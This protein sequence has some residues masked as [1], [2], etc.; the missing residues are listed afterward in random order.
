MEKKHDLDHLAERERKVVEQ[1]VTRLHQRFDGELVSAVLFGSRARGEATSKS[2][3]D[4]LVVVSH[5]DLETRKAIRHLAVETWL[6]HDIYLST[7]VWSQEHW[8]KVQEMQTLLYQ[9][10]HRDGINLM[11]L[12][13]MA[14]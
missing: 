13:S 6:E 2:D 4:V 7:R 12:C 9:N 3:M 10:I 8:K 11:S 1:F 5:A 14:D